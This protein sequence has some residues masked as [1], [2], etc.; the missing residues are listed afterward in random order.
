M[1]V[2]RKEYGFTILPRYGYVTAEIYEVYNYSKDSNM[3]IRLISKDF[4]SMF[5]S[6]NESDYLKAREWVDIQMNSISNA[7]TI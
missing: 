7:N 6:P 2:N 1:T 4:G 5:R 3:N